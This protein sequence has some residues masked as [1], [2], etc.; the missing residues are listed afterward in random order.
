MILADRSMTLLL[1]RRLIYR[2]QVKSEQLLPL[3][4]RSPIF[5]M[6]TPWP[7]RHVQV[8]H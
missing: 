7:D 1:G 8:A 2:F 5:W 3:L 6:T 4:I